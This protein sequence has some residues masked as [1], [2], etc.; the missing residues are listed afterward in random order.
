[1]PIRTWARSLLSALA[2]LALAACAQSEPYTSA[3]PPDAVDREAPSP[4]PP[5]PIPRDGPLGSAPPP[6]APPSAPSGIVTTSRPREARLPD[7]PWP[8]PRPSA[9]TLIPRQEV[10]AGLPANTSLGAVG[11]R[12]SAALDAA[13]YSERSFY[14]APGGFALVARLE[15]IRPDGTPEPDQFRF[16]PPGTGE[17]FSLAAYVQQLF[18]APEGFYR[19]IVFIV[20]DQAFVATGR[21]LTA[22]E[23][24]DLLTS[25]TNRLPASFNTRRFTDTHE[26]TALIY[27]YRKGAADRDVETLVPGR[28]S[29]RQHLQRAGVT[30]SRR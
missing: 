29:A 27:E 3:G 4:P 18:F 25:G 5:S 28:L 1:M 23:A 21:E 15:R 7:F 22:E 30:L 8:P 24:Q 2:L 17:P 20:N 10:L 19:Q 13:G 6:P 11:R 16:S 12:L 9:Q 26:V 14:A